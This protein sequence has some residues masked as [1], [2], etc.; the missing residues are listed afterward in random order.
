MGFVIVGVLLIAM[1]L[2]AVGPVAGW[3]WWIILAPFGLAVA[4][5]TWA[6]GSGYT[7]KKEME[8][9]D[10]RK[11]KRRVEAMQKLGL[12]AKKPKK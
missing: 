10:E 7:S 9:L 5:W 3:A 11:E 2:G 12:D 6:D 4:W 1:K 8:K